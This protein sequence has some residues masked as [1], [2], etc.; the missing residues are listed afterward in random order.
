MSMIAAR[1]ACLP[2]VL[3]LSSLPLFSSS[4][5]ACSCANLSCTSTSTY[6][7][8]FQRGSFLKPQ[9]QIH[10]TSHATCKLS[11]SMKG[12]QHERKLMQLMH[13]QGAGSHLCEVDGGERSGVLQE[14]VV[15]PVS[16]A[17]FGTAKFGGSQILERCARCAV[18]S[19]LRW[20]CS[21]RRQI[22]RTYNLDVQCSR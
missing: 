12:N 9:N 17:R 1:S 3:K 21:G 16:T 13:Q 14:L 6:A 2:S 7:S 11:S 18:H 15:C 20:R 19:A 5:T 4:S 10:R 22:W 8:T